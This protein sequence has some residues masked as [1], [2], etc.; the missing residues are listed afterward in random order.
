MADRSIVSRVQRDIVLAS[1]LQGAMAATA[2][3]ALPMGN[4]GVLVA[5][6]VGVL[7]L[8]LGIFSVRGSRIAADS[9][10]LIAAGRHDEAERQIEQSL[11]RFSLLKT[12][13]LFAMHNLA[14][15]RQA[16]GRW[17]EAAVLARALLKLRA[18]KAAS[19]RRAS[20]LLLAR[21]LLEMDD[22]PGAYEALSAL[23]RERLSLADSLKLLAVQLDYSARVGDWSGMLRGLRPKL[24]LAELMPSAVSAG[25][26]ALLALAARRTGQ[27]ELSRWLKDR[28][29]LLV[30]VRELC[31]HRRMLWELWQTP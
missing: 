11:R 1:F 26:Q 6:G 18:G 14:V 29:E 5:A 16:Q 24:E 3:V 2:V 4:I 17:Q 12:V 10:F 15:L 20:R 30:D 28:V 27:A 8:M 19:L 23:Y 31:G 21:S 22:L 25:A 9:P 13:K 7:W